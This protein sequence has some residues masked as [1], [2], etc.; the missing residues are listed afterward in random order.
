MKFLEEKSPTSIL[1]SYSESLWWVLNAT[2]VGDA[3]S[4]PETIPGRIFGGV[5]IFIGYALF[6]LVVGILSA[7]FSHFLKKRKRKEKI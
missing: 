6:S 5:L 2:S 3:S 1:R 4:S 7:Y